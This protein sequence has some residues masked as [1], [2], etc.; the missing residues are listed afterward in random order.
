MS[1]FRLGAISRDGRPRPVLLVDDKLIDVQDAIATQGIK[2]PA[3]EGRLDVLAMLDDWDNW[4]PV[5]RGIADVGA[6]A[7]S[8]EGAEFLAPIRYPRKLLMAGANYYDHIKEMGAEPPDKT[9]AGPYFFQKPPTTSIIAP[10]EA[11]VI[12]KGVN[13]PDWESELVAIVGRKARNVSTDEAMD[14]V[15]GYTVLNDISSRDRQ[16]RRDWYGP[17]QFD[18]MLGKGFESFAPMGPT[19][20]P[21]EF[22]A[23]PHAL[24]I[25]CSVNDEMMQDGN[26]RDMI[27]NIPEQ[28]AYLSGIFTLE[29]GDCISTGTPAGV[30][31][32]RGIFL[33][34]GDRVASEVESV[35]RLDFSVVKE[36]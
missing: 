19:I 15:A 28:V 9:K 12:P 35:C 17:F 11:V 3:V 14:Y 26:T 20:T 25:T 29:P 10:N 23:D 5:L 18:W 16:A 27:F 8:A 2:A 34:H 7:T 1:V 33:Q 21:K 22:V 24:R 36:S 31:R 4:L 32:P 13:Q 30:G 6:P